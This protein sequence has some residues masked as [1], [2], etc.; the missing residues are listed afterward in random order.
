MQRD[1]F[2]GEH[3]AFRDMVRSFIAKKITPYHERRERDGV[4][5]REVWLAAGQTGLLRI[6]VDEKQG[7]GN[8]DYRLY[9]HNDINGPRQSSAS[10]GGVQHHRVSACTALAS[11][12]MWP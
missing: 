8:P 5:S 6:D 9:L 12:G 10:A 11:A 3:E 1:I 7:G 2:T 4:V